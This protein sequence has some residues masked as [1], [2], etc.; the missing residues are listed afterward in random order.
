MSLRPSRS[1]AFVVSASLAFTAGAGGGAMTPAVATSPAFSPAAGESA[2]AAPFA[3]ILAGQSSRARATA[4]KRT[5]RVT[6]TAGGT[7][8][9]TVL[10]GKSPRGAKQVRLEKRESGSWRRAA[11]SAGKR[12]RFQFA[13]Q[14]LPEKRT[15]RVSAYGKNGKVVARSKKIVVQKKPKWEPVTGGP[16]AVLPRT[17]LNEKLE[18]HIRA[19]VNAF[20]L[21]EGF[22][23][24]EYFK[25]NDCL[26]E[27]AQK[28]SPVMLS[29]NHFEHSHMPIWAPYGIESYTTVCGNVGHEV[30]QENLA[31]MALVDGRGNDLPIDVAVNPVVD[32]WKRSSAH[33]SAMLLRYGAPENMQVGVGVAIST[34]GVAAVTLIVSGRERF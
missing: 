4:K 19:R 8:G 29:I 16:M 23:K 18:T 10:S 13:V 6:A 32:G 34:S 27:A 26:S 3:D 17:E 24:D 30:R 5:L 11:K 20:R 2:A 7:E 28:F 15:F 1:A 9:T 33:R 22:S 31:G 14:E 25:R 12:K 21:S